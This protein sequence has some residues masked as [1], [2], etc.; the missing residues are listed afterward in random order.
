MPLTKL[1]ATSSAFL[2]FLT[3]LPICSAQDKDD[4][5]KIRF[6]HPDSKTEVHLMRNQIAPVDEWHEEIWEGLFHSATGAS[7]TLE[8]ESGQMTTFQ[9]PFVYKVRTYRPVLQRWPGW[10]ALAVSSIA[11]A[12]VLRGETETNAWGLLLPIGPAAMGFYLAS[13]ME[14]VYERESQRDP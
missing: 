4:W 6:L 3:G 13:P 11:L 10:A 5:T 12:I 1:S 2:L 9:K 14:D 7:I 8:F